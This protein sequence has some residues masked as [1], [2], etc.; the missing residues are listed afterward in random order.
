MVWGH[1]QPEP[2]SSCIGEP[3]LLE[4]SLPLSNLGQRTLHR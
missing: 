1:R 4:D 3:L 2:F